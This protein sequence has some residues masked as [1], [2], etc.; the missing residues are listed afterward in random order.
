MNYSNPYIIDNNL[1]SVGNWT[2]IFC[3]RDMHTE[4]KYNKF[5]Q[6]LNCSAK[7]YIIKKFKKSDEH[8][9][10]KYSENTVLTKNNFPYKLY[11]KCDHYV[12][13]NFSDEDKNE[14]I[15]KKIQNDFPNKDI[16]LWKNNKFNR[17]IDD[18]IHHQVIMKEPQPIY[19]LKNLIIVCR[20][21]PREPIFN[22]KK[23][24]VDIWPSKGNGRDAKLTNKGEE[25]CQEMGKYLR[26]C[27]APFIDIDNCKI[28]VY[29]SPVDRTIKSANFFLKQFTNTKSIEVIKN[30]DFG[31]FRKFTKSEHGTIK[32]IMNNIKIKED[33]SDIDDALLDIYGIKIRKSHDYF[34]A[35][36]TIQCYKFEKYKLPEEWTSELH[37]KLIKITTIFYNKLYD[38]CKCAKLTSKS[39][40][41]FIKSILKDDNTITFISTHDCNIFA[42][43]KL[44]DDQI[45][46]IPDFCANIRYEVWENINESVVRIYYNDLFVK[47]FYL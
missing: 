24:P 6:T 8:T 44:I 2:T 13:W 45:Y 5:I 20:H 38:N 30:N 47:E 21:G 17:S 1:K 27:Y 35:L 31:G 14:D 15:F 18:I 3:R 46:T 9:I 19:K 16:I 10:K 43:A 28:N 34:D 40:L 32:S 26:L 12:L 29:S 39:I 7:E 36:S 33:T 25:Y 23:L 42:L 37:E 4:N 22:T 41:D 11:E